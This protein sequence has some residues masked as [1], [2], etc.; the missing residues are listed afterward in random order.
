M[1]LPF[2]KTC[3]VVMNPVPATVSVKDAPPAMASS[4]E[5]EEI[6][7]VGV[8]MVPLPPQQ[9]RSRIA[10][11]ADKVSAA[12]RK[13]INPSLLPISSGPQN[14]SLLIAGKAERG[15][16]IRCLPNPHHNLAHEFIAPRRA[17]RQLGFGQNAIGWLPRELRSGPENRMPRRDDMLHSDV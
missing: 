7:G 13:R 9:F 4:G 6:T 15:T 1:Q 14:Y 3:E 16:P 12:R 17:T 5:R 2:Q 8:K 10:N 11:P